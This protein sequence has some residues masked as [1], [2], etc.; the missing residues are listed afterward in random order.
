MVNA[1]SDRLT[2]EV[3]RDKQLYTQSFSR[4][5]PQGKLKKVGAGE[6]PPRHGGQ[7]PSRSDRSSARAPFSSRRTLYR[8]A[9]SKAYLFRGVE[10]RWS[11]D[12]ALL[13]DDDK[14]PAQ[15]VLHFPG[16]LADFLQGMLAGRAVV[17]GRPFAGSAAV[18]RR[19]GP[20]GMG[21]GL[22]R[23]RGRLLQLLLQH[24]RRRPRAAR[25]ST[26]CA[27]R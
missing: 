13:K 23:G 12:P 27:T 20:G 10:I 1:L 24:H 14:T 6:Q 3:A 19:A 9:R 7:L 5:E 11:C 21:G 18:R 16:G 15:E 17:G 8:M 4:G 25:T 26:A 22:A 2:V